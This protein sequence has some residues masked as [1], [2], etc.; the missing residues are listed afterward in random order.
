MKATTLGAQDAHR[1]QPAREGNVAA[2]AQ[3][4]ADGAK[5]RTGAC[6]IE[7]EHTLVRNNGS[8]VPYASAE[9]GAHD[10]KAAHSGRGV[11]WIL[12][13][14][15]ET[16]PDLT[17]DADG[18][19][20]GVARP[21]EAITL[22]PAA[23]VELSAGPFERLADAKRV[24][25]GF[26]QTLG[27]IVAE[28]NAHVLAVGYH[29]T[30]RS[31]ELALIPKKRYK[32]MSL[33]FS[34]IGPWGARMMRGS[35]STQVSIDYTSEADCLR[36]MRAAFRLAPLFA[37]LCDNSPRFENAV[38][39]HELM[40]TAI[41]NGCDPDRCGV[42]PGIFDKD[43]SFERYANIVLDTPA[44]LVPCPRGEWCYSEHSFADFYASTP[45]AR[46]D[47]EH[48][49]SMQFTDIRLK[50]YIE[51][52]PAD[53][54]PVPFAISYA[55]LVKGLFLNDASLAAVEALVD[56]VS[57]DS[58][59][60]AK[61]AL[62]ESGYNAQVFGQDAAKLVE[63][64]LDIAAGGLTD[65]ERAFL[66]P[67]AK[68]AEHRTTLATLALEGGGNK[69][70]GVRALCNPLLSADDLSRIAGW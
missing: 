33:Y 60:A 15:A 50:T 23:Q 68:L 19:L 18:D 10:S 37:L 36:K 69:G 38:R 44:I 5:K 25:E 8:A 47:I 53:A 62:M 45:M 22:E 51:L 27:S 6:G 30:A 16:Y 28:A 42:V 67:L 64:I 59:A 29:P 65:D 31:T 35:A 9:N 14:L 70:E 48:A 3:Y 12:H 40:R 55:A 7:L 11:E 61:D 41:W 26:E 63:S 32:F 66:R 21:H 57:E 56:G 43:F 17:R 24:F 54:L 58:I 1:N 2:I 52:R 46:T 39:P 49:L 4:F 13:R 34:E 20:L